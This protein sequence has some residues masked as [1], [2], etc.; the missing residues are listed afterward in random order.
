MHRMNRSILCIP[1]N[2]R[3]SFVV[4][5]SFRPQETAAGRGN[6]VRA[7]C[8][9]IERPGRMMRAT[10]SP[11]GMIGIAALVICGMAAAPAGSPPPYLHAPSVTTYARHDPAGVTIL[12]EG[13][14]LKPVG[15]HL[16]LARWP[17]G[18][19]LSPDGT[20]PFVASK[21]VGPRGPLPL[22]AVGRGAAG[23]RRQHRDIRVPPGAAA[24]RAPLRSARADVPSL[25]IS[26]QRGAARSYRGRA[27]HPRSRRSERARVVLGLG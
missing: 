24:I 21:G 23:L 11:L 26:E 27:P 18:L 10:L 3:S 25:R 22:R 20:T 5:L 7:V 14:Y 2:F 4:N 12:P 9:H 16:P 15:R 17:H 6:M 19:A 13:R 1:V 8:F